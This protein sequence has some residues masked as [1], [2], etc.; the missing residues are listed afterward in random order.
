MARTTIMR[1]ATATMAARRMK[2][3]GHA[4]P[5]VALAFL[6]VVIGAFTVERLLFGDFFGSSIFVRGAQPDAGTA[7]GVRRLGAFRAASV[8]TPALYLVILGFLSA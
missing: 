6:S 1:M 7:R 3:L 4:G 8:A 5:L 2:L